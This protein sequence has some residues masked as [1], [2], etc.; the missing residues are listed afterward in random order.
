MANLSESD[1]YTHDGLLTFQVICLEASACEPAMDYL[2]HAVA[3]GW[4]L[5]EFLDNASSLVGD[6]HHQW[7][8][9]CRTELSS[10]MDE[11]VKLAFSDKA[12]V[13]DARV[14][15][16]LCIDC[17]DMGFDES[18]EQLVRWHSALNETGEVLFPVIEDE[19]AGKAE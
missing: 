2:T 7:A 10:H 4:T 19:L 6:L 5:R 17:D 11:A 14:A 1:L 16:Q 15:A 13:A 3:E 12:S 18:Y 9:W 8:E